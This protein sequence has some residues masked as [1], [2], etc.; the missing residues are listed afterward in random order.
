MRCKQAGREGGGNGGKIHI[1]VHGVFL[2]VEIPAR[3]DPAWV[4]PRWIDTAHR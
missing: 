2:L 1:A 4:D 3:L